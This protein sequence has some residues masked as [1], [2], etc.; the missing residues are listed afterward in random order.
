[1]AKKALSIYFEDN[2]IKLVETRDN[3]VDRWANIPLDPGLVVGGV[4]M[5][6]IKVAESVRKVFAALAE[7]KS[8]VNGIKKLGDM[9]SGKGK[10]IAGL[11][12][13]DS[14]YRVISL[15]VI[16]ESMLGEAIKREAARVLPVS[17]DELYLSYQRIPGATGETRI[18]I[19]AFPK[20]PADSLIK[21]L[22]LAGVKPQVLDLVPLSL[23]LPV[24]A[25]KAIIVDFNHDNLNIVVLAD[26]VPQVIRSLALQS[27]TKNIEE[28]LATISEE[29]SRTVAFF[30]STHQQDPLDS[31]TPVFVSGELVK[32]PDSWKTLVGKINARVAVLPSVIEYPDDF[33]AIE[34][35]VALSL[36]TKEL[37]LEKAPGAYSLV[38][39]NVLPV[40]A[41]KKGVNPYNIILPVVAVA[42]IASL[43]FLFNMY[44]T[45]K[46]DV[47]TLQLQ[48]AS[49]QVTITANAKQ[50]AALTESN[51]TLS[52]QI[53]PVLDQANVVKT[54]INALNANRKLT[55]D[56][57]QKI[58]SSS[59][60]IVLSSIQYNN[61]STV[62]AGLSVIGEA[63][64]MI[65]AQTLR[66][67]DGFDVLVTS[68]AVDSDG[69]GYNF[70]LN[71]K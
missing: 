54:K 64:A 4:I 2:S 17:L 43:Y 51:R 6:E 30:N 52:E 25:P 24:N 57:L 41:R 61:S 34:Y 66:A 26:R 33:P 39:M 38:N 27:E 58:V 47:T 23:V 71:L 56:N 69:T 32:T 28:N 36:A 5:D 29:F 3:R 12:G 60:G 16:S 11:S 19:A 7:V 63:N 8:Q 48:I 37:E 68:I 22:R 35:V 13:R 67:D 46:N 20:K 1:M 15:P 9:F 50:I 40:Y 62:I 14:L 10:L 70:T 65:Y 44:Q 21:T 53:T 49:Q 42:G 55:D 45:A 31:N 59:Q 18:F